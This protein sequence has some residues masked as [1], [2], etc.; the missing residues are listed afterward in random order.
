MESG[1]VDLLRN[2]RKKAESKVV[3]SLDILSLYVK[4]SQPTIYFSFSMVQYT[5]DTL[6]RS[7]LWLRDFQVLI[8]RIVIPITPPDRQ[9]D[10]QEI[11]VYRE[12][13]AHEHG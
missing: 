10:A 6:F 3:L 12:Y 1:T 2:R 11:R 13:H 8:L 5:S 9:D 7:H 4:N